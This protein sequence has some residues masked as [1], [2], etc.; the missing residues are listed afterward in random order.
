MVDADRSEIGIVDIND[1]NIKCGDGLR[2]EHVN[3]MGTDKEY[4][5]EKFEAEV[6]HIPFQAMYRYFPVDDSSHEHEGYIFNH[7]SSRFEIID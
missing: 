7:R 2:V 5:D 1:R 3:Y 4:V 6:R